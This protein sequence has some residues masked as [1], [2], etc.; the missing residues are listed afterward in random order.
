M[1]Y[2]SFFFSLISTCATVN[3][4]RKALDYTRLSINVFLNYLS[5]INIVERFIYVKL[6]EMVGNNYLLLLYPFS[7]ARASL[8]R[9][10]EESRLDSPEYKVEREK[11]KKKI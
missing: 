2:E 7:S 6:G 8:Q 1:R 9:S 3:F 5:H 10:V 4:P 11:K